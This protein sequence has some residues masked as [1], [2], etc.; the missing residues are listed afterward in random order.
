VLSMVKEGVGG[1]SPRIGS[2][3]DLQIRAVRYPGAWRSMGMRRGWVG[4]GGEPGRTSRGRQRAQALIGR[5]CSRVVN[6]KIAA[7][8]LRM[9]VTLAQLRASN[10]LSESA[11][12]P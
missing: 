2:T 8:S 7:H 6:D 10:P 5:R 1:S 11:A 9:M 4:T 12:S 3:K